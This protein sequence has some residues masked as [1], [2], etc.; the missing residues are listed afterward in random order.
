MISETLGLKSNGVEVAIPLAD[1]VSLVCSHPCKLTAQAALQEAVI[2]VAKWNRH[3]K[4]TLNTDRTSSPSPP[5]KVLTTASER[6]LA[7]AGV[8]LG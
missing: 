8:T 1:D 3:H 6:V 4:M 5:L 7:L 2:S